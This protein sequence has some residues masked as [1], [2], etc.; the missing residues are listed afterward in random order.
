MM[1]TLLLMC[2]GLALPAINHKS[3]LARDGTGDWDIVKTASA[4]HSIG[5]I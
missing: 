4:G 1:P 5:G 3:M 2:N